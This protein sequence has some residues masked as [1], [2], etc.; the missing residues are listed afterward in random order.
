[1]RSQI[2]GLMATIM[3]MVVI[4]V[5]ITLPANAQ[6]AEVTNAIGNLPLDQFCSKNNVLG[7]AWGIRTLPLTPKAKRGSVNKGLDAKFAPFDAYGFNTSPYSNQL[8]EA[9]FE[10]DFDNIAAGKTAMTQLA[11]RYADTGWLQQVGTL[12]L[13]DEK[14][15]FGAPAIGSIF[16]YA[17]PGDANAAE[18]SGVKL[19]LTQSENIVTATCRNGK[20]FQAHITETYGKYPD[21]L[22]KPVRIAV[23]QSVPTLRTDCDDTAKRDAIIDN[24][25]NGQSNIAGTEEIDAESDYQ[26]RLAA[27]KRAKLIGSGK[28]SEED[29]L[30]KE[31]ELLN[32]PAALATIEK[33]MATMK[34][35]F[36]GTEALDKYEKAGDTLNLCRGLVDFETKMRNAMQ[37]SASGA[38]SHLTLRNRLFDDLANKV[39]FVF[40]E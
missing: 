10:A 24:F 33:D 35:I 27:W 3:V 13:D 14:L 16:L 37:S 29:V 7:N 1:M 12:S 26:E 38:G 40:P 34:T 20:F 31:M 39:A 19:E 18:P 23:I 2:T 22:P 28:I 11:Q 5:T 21:D 25:K 32:D 15:E 8:Y 6:P 9:I 4:T 30:E 17:T 36:A